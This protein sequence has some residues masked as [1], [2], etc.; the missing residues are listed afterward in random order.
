V[1]HRKKPGSPG[2]ILRN[3]RHYGIKGMRWGIRKQDDLG[4]LASKSAKTAATNN[5]STKAYMAA[6]QKLM[7]APGSEEQLAANKEKFL[8]KFE[9]SDGKVQRV[10]EKGVSP[11]SADGKKGLTEQQKKALIKVGIGVGV[12]GGV[13]ALTY[14]Q[15]KKI[16]GMAGKPI[17]AETFKK[18]T[19]YSQLKTWGN[20]SYIQPQSFTREGFELPA[21]HV[22]H[23]ISTRA[24][25]GFSHNS[26]TYSVHSI[27]DYHR[28]IAGFR[29]EEMIF[30]KQKF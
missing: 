26:G 2:D 18:H 1:D 7:D 13:V 4:G 10:D 28:Y 24:E 6:N 30:M 23:R 17:D 20:S 27:E 21:G 12:V 11:P 15:K 5:T 19:L 14:L 3:L 25:T 16:L 22:F 29:Q 9:S 8:R